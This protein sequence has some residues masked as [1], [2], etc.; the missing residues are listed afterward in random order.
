MIPS[1][2][3]E[4]I[5]D[6]PSQRIM[7]ENRA[8]RP[9]HLSNSRNGSVNGSR[10]VNDN[11]KRNGNET[12]TTPKLMRAYLKSQ[13]LWKYPLLHQRGGPRYSHFY[14]DC[15]HVHCTSPTFEDQDG[16][17]NGKN[18]IH[19]QRSFSIPKVVCPGYGKLCSCSSSSWRTRRVYYAWMDLFRRNYH[20][21]G[22][23]VKHIYY[24]SM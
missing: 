19:A 21:N 24:S 8:K 1:L 12:S 14:P 5:L 4:K 2:I 23:V 22:L 17:G 11:L 7:W 10:N 6:P 15:R 13:H 3:L 9:L 18:N 16:N 20:G